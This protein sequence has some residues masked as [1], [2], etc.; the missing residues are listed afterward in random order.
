[1]VTEKF[2]FN[3]PRDHA[4]LLAALAEAC[5]WCDEPRNR[6][7]LAQLLSGPAYINQSARVI[8]PALQG[9][10][11]CGHDQLESVSD[12]VVFH[13]NGANAPTHARAAALQA[14]LIE[15]GLLP[16]KAAD[17]SF[18]GR[19]FRED[20]FRQA[21]KQTTHELVTQ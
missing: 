9:L 15:A 5:A 3:R 19:V 13:R 8:L 6:E 17:A 4:A 1:M 16:A 21:L 20:L 11:D 7:P 10:F 14:E 12:F 18:P 2:A